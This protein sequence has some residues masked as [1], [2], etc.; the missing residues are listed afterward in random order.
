M[1]NCSLVIGVLIESFQNGTDQSL[2]FSG[3]LVWRN[4]I[5]I[6]NYKIETE[7]VFIG[8]LKTGYTE[9]KE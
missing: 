4:L 1:K 6:E 5:E 9:K 8:E 2:M 7:K 3:S